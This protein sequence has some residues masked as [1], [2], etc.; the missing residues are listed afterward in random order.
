MTTVIWMDCGLGLMFS[1]ERQDLVGAYVSASRMLANAQSS[2]NQPFEDAVT[3]LLMSLW[4][5]MEGKGDSGV[6]MRAEASERVL[7]ELGR[8][9]A[10]P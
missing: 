4:R 8:E 7:T 2:D 6:S 9:I 5:D 1:G 10:N 3:E